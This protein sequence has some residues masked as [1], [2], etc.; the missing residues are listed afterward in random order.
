MN[1]NNNLF[2]AKWPVI[3]HTNYLPF[4]KISCY[5]DVESKPQSHWRYKLEILV[6]IKSITP[7]LYSFFA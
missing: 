6:K 1:K 3:Q 2:N 4:R 5:I 7:T